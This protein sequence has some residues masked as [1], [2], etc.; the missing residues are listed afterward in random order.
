MSFTP[1]SKRHKAC[2]P[3]HAAL[4][5]SYRVER[6]RQERVFEKQTGGYP[7]DM[8]HAKARGHRLIDFRDWLKAHKGRSS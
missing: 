8:A 1:C 3:A 2:S 4:V 5:E 7:G 6:W